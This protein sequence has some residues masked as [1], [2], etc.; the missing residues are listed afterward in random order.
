MHNWKFGRSSP[1]LT[2]FRFLDW[3][4]RIVLMIAI[5]Q[6]QLQKKHEVATVVTAF[7]GGHS[8]YYFV[9]IGNLVSGCGTPWSY[10][11]FWERRTIGV[12]WIREKVNRF[13]SDFLSDIE[14]DYIWF[15]ERLWYEFT[16][17]FREK[18]ILVSTNKTVTRWK[19]LLLDGGVFV[20]SIEGESR[21][22]APLECLK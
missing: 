13:A 12:G 6:I 21:T 3:I 18:S 17:M 1:I 5:K 4:P 9:T 7:P 22:T 16:S 2:T 15:G 19:N 14:R 10:T 20:R 11:S 8:K